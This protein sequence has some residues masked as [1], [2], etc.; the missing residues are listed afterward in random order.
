MYFQLLPFQHDVV[1]YS[2]KRKV[3][4]YLSRS[5]SGTPRVGVGPNV[6]HKQ[7]TFS[8]YLCTGNINCFIFKRSLINRRL[9][10]TLKLEVNYFSDR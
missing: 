2:Q 3:S 8:D 4:V 9:S 10:L 7:H 1:H 5:D 6:S